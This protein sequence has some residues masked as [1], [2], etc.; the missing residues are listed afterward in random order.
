MAQELVWD[1]FSIDR[2][3]GFNCELAVKVPDV[4][5]IYDSAP[6]IIHGHFKEVGE[7]RLSRRLGHNRSR[8]LILLPIDKINL[9]VHQARVCSQ[10][11]CSNETG[12]TVSKNENS[13]V[14]LGLVRFC[15]GFRIGILNCES[16]G[17]YD[18]CDS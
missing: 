15:K 16:K 13:T 3:S 5:H 10:Q 11:V 18:A 2:G 12:R 9:M 14:F 7:I 17:S 4:M 6:K 1:L 8:S